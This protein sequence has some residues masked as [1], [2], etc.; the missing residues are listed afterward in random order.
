MALTKAQIEILTILK[1]T[2]NTQIINPTY[3][4][5]YLTKDGER[6]KTITYPSFIAIKPYLKTVDGRG[7][8][9]FVFDPEAEISDD[10]PARKRE[11]E[12]KRREAEQAVRLAAVKTKAD[13]ATAWFEC[14]GPY[15]VNFEGD[16]FTGSGSILFNGEFV[17]SIRLVYS[18]SKDQTFEDMLKR[19]GNIEHLSRIKEMLRRANR[20]D[21]NN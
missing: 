9:R 2:P 4:A 1:D 17:A 5:A 8:D 19:P 7:C 16:Y 20:E 12:N 6:I 15:M 10:W 3:R 14:V 13:E 18:S 21:I 11:I